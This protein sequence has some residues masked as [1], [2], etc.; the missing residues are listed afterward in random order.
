MKRV[1]R[2]VEGK[3]DDQG[4]R[5]GSG[6]DGWKKRDTDSGKILGKERAEKERVKGGYVH[7]AY[8]YQWQ[9]ATR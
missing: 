4:T 5:L 6:K 7:C 3:D 8:Q 9:L 2:R 1:E